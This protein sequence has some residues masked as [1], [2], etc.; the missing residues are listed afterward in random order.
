MIDHDLGDLILNEDEK[1]DNTKS[2][3]ILTIVA[4]LIAILVIAIMMAQMVLDDNDENSSLLASQEDS[5]VSSELQLDESIR[6]QS[7]EEALD[8]VTKLLTEE[9]MEQNSTKEANSTDE[10]KPDIKEIDEEATT[11]PVVAT[12]ISKPEKPVVKKP[13]PAVK[14]PAPKPKPKK[15]EPQKSHISKGSFYIQVGSFTKKPSSRFLSVITN[16]GFSYKLHSSG[17][18]LI[19]SYSSR[20]MATKDLPRVKDRINKGAFIINIK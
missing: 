5:I 7:D 2:K 8:D 10:I 18:L 16:S 11:A 20:D 9:S 3:G 19:G 17:K 15:S 1:K 12:P 14:K 13:K 6:E 4:L